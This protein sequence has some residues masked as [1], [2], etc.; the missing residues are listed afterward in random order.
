M[1]LLL[2]CL[3]LAIPQ[4]CRAEVPK[5]LT[6]RAF[7]SASLAE[8]ANHYISLGEEGTFQELNTFIAAHSALTN[9]SSNQRFSVD[10]RIAW[11]FRILYVPKKPVPMRVPKTGAWITG[12]IV[13]LRPPLFGWLSL[14]EA[15]MPVET[16]PLYPLA[17]SGTTFFVMEERYT[18]RQTPETIAHYM[19]YC[20][21]NGAF[22]KTPVAVPTREQALSDLELFRQSKAW[23]SIKWVDNY[24]ISFPHGEE[25]LWPIIKKQAMGIP[26]SAVADDHSTNTVETQVSTR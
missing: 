13:P 3:A 12:S 4:F 9:E 17:L 23:K 25:W 14:P 21:N 11:I 10:E 24:G 7:T 22:R 18:P 16:W 15:S 1:K 20:R 5:L 8:A 2:I 26:E 6:E 19:E